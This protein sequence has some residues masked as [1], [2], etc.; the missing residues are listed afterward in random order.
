MRSR[1]SR[2]K[3]QRQIVDHFLQMICTL[4]QQ[5]GIYTIELQSPSTF[6]V[7]YLLHT[8]DVDIEFSKT[9]TEFIKNRQHQ[10]L[11]RANSIFTN[12]VFRIIYSYLSILEKPESQGTS[13]V[14]HQNIQL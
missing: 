12:E 5:Y 13:P 14:Q 6:R 8:D 3:I 11:Q 4:S 7:K 2:S 10:N 1:I 9:F